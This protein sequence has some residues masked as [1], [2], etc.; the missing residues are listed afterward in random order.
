MVLV[1]VVIVA[2]AAADTLSYF[3]TAASLSGAM[4]NGQTLPALKSGW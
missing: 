3:A 1:M 4:Q 2:A